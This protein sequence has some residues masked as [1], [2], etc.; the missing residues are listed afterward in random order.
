[1]NIQ[2]LSPIWA[3]RSVVRALLANPDEAN[4]A[5]CMKIPVQGYELSIALDSSHGPGDLTRSNLRIF[6]PSGAD[7]TWS[8]LPE[9]AERGCV[10]ACA[11][12]L[13]EAFAAIHELVAQPA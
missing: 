7:V 1:M 5:L 4:K 6:S 9:Y 3:P 10:P 13:Q 8:V 12:T 11:Q 2:D